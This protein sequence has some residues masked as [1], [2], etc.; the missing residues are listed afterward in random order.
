MNSGVITGYV[1]AVDEVEYLMAS[2]RVEMVI[3]APAAQKMHQKCTLPLNKYL[4]SEIC[5][6]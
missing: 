5:S 4:F 1:I 6:R 2:E 3:L